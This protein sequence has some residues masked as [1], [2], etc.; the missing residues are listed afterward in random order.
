MCRLTLM[1]Q[2]LWCVFT[3][4]FQ[5]PLSTPAPPCH[6]GVIS[7][8]SAKYWR[9]KQLK[10]T[11]GKFCLW[12]DL[13][14][15]AAHEVAFDCSIWHLAKNTDFFFCLLAG[16]IITSLNMS[17]LF[18]LNLHCSMHKAQWAKKKNSGTPDSLVQ[19]YSF[20]SAPTMQD[21][22]IHMGT[23]EDSA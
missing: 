17:S 12:L 23:D 10:A 6:E 2:C 9:T 22:D 13:L 16:I 18:R 5:G 21:I 15:L 7:P 1:Q 14:L 19:I 8:L 11:C 4:L 20:S 3:S